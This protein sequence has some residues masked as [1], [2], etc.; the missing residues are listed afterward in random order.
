MTGHVAGS[1]RREIFDCRHRELRA[2]S[3]IFLVTALSG[4]SWYIHTVRHV[5]HFR[6]HGVHLEWVE[7]GE[8]VSA[9]DHVT[10][11]EVAF[12]IRHI[13]D[14]VGRRSIPRH[15]PRSVPFWRFGEGLP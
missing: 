10:G 13:D 12:I 14:A 11:L 3:L 7:V 9:A 5:S 1:V 6:A 4:L 2:R 8:G 15:L